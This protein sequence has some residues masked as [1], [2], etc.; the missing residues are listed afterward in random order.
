MPCLALP[1]PLRTAFPG[2]VVSLVLIAL[3]VAAPPAAAGVDRWTTLGPP[4][5][6]VRLLVAD[7]SAPG[8]I[9]A[10]H[11]E[12]LFKTLDGGDLWLPLRNGL[13]AGFVEHVALDPSAPATVYAA[14]RSREAPEP[15]DGLYRS[16]DAGA[17]WVRR[18]A[19][20]A[21]ESFA[22][23]PG[24]PAALFAA[25]SLDP[26]LRT[27]TVF[28]SLDAGAT[29]Q[30]VLGV[31]VGPL[32]FRG[33]TAHPAI[34][35]TVYAVLANGLLRSTDHGGTWAPA[36]PPL[37]GDPPD[38]LHSLTVAPSAPEVLYAVGSAAFRSDDGGA[39][40]RA[41]G[42]APCGYGPVVVGPREPRTVDQ[43]CSE[44]IA[45]SRDGGESWEPVPVEAAGSLPG[46]SA[47]A[48]D[49]A[50][51]E[52]LYVATGALG[53]YTTRSGGLRWRRASAGLGSLRTYS[54]ALDPR[55]PRSLYA[56][57]AA[58]YGPAG[59]ERRWLWR[60]LDAGATW[61]RWL[62]GLAALVSQVVPDP[63]RPGSVY[64]ATRD[65][66]FAW[67]EGGGG[68]RRLWPSPVSRVA[69]DAGDP[70]LL[71]A[72]SGSSVY[73]SL[74]GGRTW[75]PS[76]GF[77]EG[78]V[79]QGSRAYALLPDPDAP[80]RIYALV[81]DWLVGGESGYRMYRS[82]DA[83]RS[84]W[85]KP[86]WPG[87][88][89]LY[90]APAGIAD[91]PCV[92]Y[93]GSYYTY[94]STDG[95]DTWTETGFPGEMVLAV[96]G[97]PPT[98]YVER[99]GD[100]V[101]RSRDGGATWTRLEALGDLA[102]GWREVLA[103]HPGA[104]ERLFRYHLAG[105]APLRSI[106]AV[107]ARPLVLQGGRFEAR[108][109]W[110]DA[111]GRYGPARPVT[112]AEAA[113]LFVLPGRQ[114]V[115]SALEAL[116][117]RAAAGRFRVL[118]ASLL[119][120]EATVT[121][122]DR[123]TGLSR[124]LFFPA[125]EAVSHLDAESFPPLPEPPGWEPAGAGADLSEVPE[126]VRAAAVSTLCQPGPNTLCFLG[127]R[128]RVRVHR[129]GGGGGAR[130]APLAWPAGVAP[131]LWETGGAWFD[132]PAAPSVVVQMVDGERLNGSV[133]VLIG[134]LSE[135][136]YV[137]RVTDTATGAARIYVH[138]A[139]PPG[140][141]ADLSAFRLPSR[142]RRSPGGPPAGPRPAG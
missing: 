85:E 81:E 102:V 70:A 98:L 20:P 29:W 137:V 21:W 55:A 136:A 131:L 126:D 7:P 128:F 25:G 51:P 14:V 97:A 71:Y 66:L 107:D 3:L 5:G 32:D 38:V 64:L 4:G 96:P 86:G 88:E 108:A 24:D 130:T 122:T 44:H 142:A 13:P 6:P 74:D 2:L 79:W 77:P 93:A 45:R 19:L 15:W 26:E 127:G 42:P 11:E 48:V 123:A 82:D 33:L 91:E 76:L 118:G 39:S 117:E 37:A 106:Q 80:G 68:L 115:L 119:P 129:Q 12:G 34:A 100:G 121:V 23:G 140:S 134:G 116:D 54:L 65:G 1:R 40:W 73:R 31:P 112:L 89:T 103:A 99:P 16:L 90:L 30:A 69:P 124:D 110:R 60:S 41:L 8:H 59:G 78:A 49:P 84:W 139:G 58:P 114:K 52:R 111:D 53:V 18:G 94:R 36:G 132:D 62:P 101:F 27:T 56:V 87:E 61:S 109:A 133:W 63:H 138:A 92:L 104:P 35:G 50:S 17:T 46:L 10:V 105:E 9:Y 47:L 141:V 57:T 28:R 83:G 95:G 43:V 67:S 113:G 120:L 125:D 135:A 72:V 22:A 75:E